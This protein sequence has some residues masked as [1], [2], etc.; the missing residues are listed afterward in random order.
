MLLRFWHYTSVIILY[1]YYQTFFLLNYYTITPP[2]SLANYVRFFWVLESDEPYT[3]RNM[4]DGC[5]EIFFHYNGVFDEIRDDN[6]RR[7]SV[8]SGIQGP[9][10]HFKRFSIDKGFGMFGIYLYPFAVKQFF[11]L[12]VTVLTNQMPDLKTF[13]G[14]E[15]A[16]LEE[17]IMIAGDTGQ[18][19]K[20]IVDFLERKLIK[21]TS[22]IHPVF[23]AIRQI[24][25]SKGNLRINEL[26][27]QY[28]LSNRQ[29][30]RRFKELAGLSPKLYT[31]II[32]FQAASNEYGNKNKSLTSIA[33][34][35]GY[36]DQSHFIHEFKEFSGLHP[37]QYFS[38]STEATKWIDAGD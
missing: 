32:R 8:C 1:L 4:A 12:P 27:Y 24:L 31:R 2:P 16:I 17:R 25:H 34:D 33:Y 11:S 28:Y 13:L 23:N 15:G 3:H 5:A 37:R 21:N 9:S 38:G 19:V 14:N 35:C 7:Q 6:A 26:S 36:Y 30:E 20:I 18:R 29:F 10:N 22:T